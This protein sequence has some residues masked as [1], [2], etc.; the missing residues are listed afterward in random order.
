MAR[1]RK[2]APIPLAEVKVG[3][4]FLAP[5]ED[6]RL[7][8][9][10]VLRAK[11]DHSEVLVAASPWVGTQPPD[12]A[13]PVLRDLLRTTHHSWGDEPY[14]CWVDDPVPATFTRLGKIAPTEA[15]A[16]MEGGGWTGWGSFPQQVFLQWRW[17]HERDKVLAEDAQEQ[18]A[19]E[20]AREEERQAYKPLPARTLEE[21]RGQPAFPGWAGYVEPAF[22]R[23]ARRIIRE[24]IDALIALGPDASEPARIDEIR[25]CIERFNAL[26]EDIDTIEREDICEL[27]GE[28]ADLIDLDDYEEALTGARDW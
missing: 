8:V 7:C 24:T 5:L 18:Q 17:D 9:C 23:E 26:D 19:A 10:R 13:D 3:D 21:M 28:I 14:V 25:H 20:A 12:L 6:G 16:A 4:A 22:L 15:Q 2:P 27:I 1:K 11:R